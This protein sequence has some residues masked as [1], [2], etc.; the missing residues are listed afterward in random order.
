MQP[1]Q[2]L[3]LFGRSTA[4]LFKIPLP[5]E[6][7]PPCAGWL[8]EWVP[9]AHS[10][11]RSKARRGH[12]SDNLGQVIIP[13]SSVAIYCMA[14]S[15]AQPLQLVDFWWFNIRTTGC[16]IHPFITFGLH[17]SAGL[18]RFQG[19]PLRRERIFPVLYLL[20]SVEETQ[21]CNLRAQSHWWF[22]LNCSYKKHLIRQYWLRTNQSF[23]LIRLS[24]M[25]W[26]CCPEICNNSLVWFL[27][28]FNNIYGRV[29]KTNEPSSN[30][31]F[32]TKSGTLR[33]FYVH[34]CLAAQYIQRPQ[35]LLR[36]SW[37]FIRCGPTRKLNLA[38]I[39]FGMQ[40][41]R[42]ASI[43]RKY[44]LWMNHFIRWELSRRIWNLLIFNQRSIFGRVLEPF[45]QDLFPSLQDERSVIFPQVH[46]QEGTR[47]RFCLHCYL[48]AW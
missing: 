43:I 17:D 45:E 7:F 21:S 19:F 8:I 4:P 12:F 27:K 31:K 14:V 6:S 41:S 47:R 32:V 42:G 26:N 44:W 23:H 24:R 37:Y 30:R 25:I 28:D 9:S 39:S 11:T 35:G 10:S 40:I 16:T 48:A 36:R 38:T 29:F 2:H 1:I 46:Y 13:V 20:G 33:R 18:P 34:C 5:F 3:N 22:T 15:Q